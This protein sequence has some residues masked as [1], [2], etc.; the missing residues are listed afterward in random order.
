MTGVVT[1]IDQNFSKAI[2]SIGPSATLEPST[3]RL[4]QDG[5][6]K[7]NVQKLIGKVH[8]GGVLSGA[9]D[10]RQGYP[11]STTGIPQVNFLFAQHHLSMF[12]LHVLC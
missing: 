11:H 1:D 8:V 4:G 12:V 10:L 5:T 3:T 9:I 6:F 7:D 2:T